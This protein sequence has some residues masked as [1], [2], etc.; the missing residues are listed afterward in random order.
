MEIGTGFELE[1][2]GVALAMMAC[3]RDKLDQ[4]Y[5]D[6]NVKIK[7]YPEIFVRKYSLINNIL[8]LLVLCQIVYGC[9]M[10]SLGQIPLG[11]L[12]SAPGFLF[13]Q[14]LAAFFVILLMPCL[15]EGMKM[16]RAR[17]KAPAFDN[18]P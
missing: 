15:F 4:I 7:K 9:L 11:E 1:A 16:D 8:I 18:M 13:F 14:L 17:A 3:S 10:L 5:M 12:E 6:Y 2:I